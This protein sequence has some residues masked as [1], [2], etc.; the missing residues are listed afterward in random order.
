VLARVAYTVP[1][2]R[3]SL[4]IQ[5]ASDWSRPEKLN[6]ILS[7]PASEFV[8]ICKNQNINARRA[9]NGSIN[10]QRQECDVVF[11]R[12]QPFFEYTSLKPAFR[13]ILPTKGFISLF[14]VKFT[15]ATGRQASSVV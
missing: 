2:A 14:P 9:W 12:T 8:K 11:Q 6:V 10:A 13:S 4:V 1:S 3:R 15:P 5:H 7:A